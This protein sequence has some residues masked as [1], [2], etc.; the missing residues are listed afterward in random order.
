M[1]TVTALEISLLLRS[2]RYVIIPDVSRTMTKLNVPHETTPWGTPTPG[3]VTSRKNL[4]YFTQIIIYGFLGNNGMPGIPDPDPELNECPIES[5]IESSVGMNLQCSAASKKEKH[6]LWINVGA[7]CAALIPFQ[8]G[9]QSYI[10]N[11][12]TK[13]TEEKEKQKREEETDNQRPTTAGKTKCCSREPM[14]GHKEAGLGSFLPPT[15]LKRFKVETPNGYNRSIGKKLPLAV[16][17][18]INLLR[19]SELQE[20]TSSPK[21]NPKRP[22]KN[23]RHPK[24]EPKTSKKEAKKSKKNPRS[25]P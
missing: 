15:A 7:T 5:L 11:T 4:K 12:K 22:K 17:G 6:E 24:K 14:G 9:M 13:A 19:K 18:F 16:Q 20:K 23:P 25:I 2:L 10:I 8:N 21:K 3:F 1:S